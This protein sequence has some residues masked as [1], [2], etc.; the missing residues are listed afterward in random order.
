MSRATQGALGHLGKE[1][2]ERLG[3]VILGKLL[4]FSESQ[5]APSASVLGPEL[6]DMYSGVTHLLRGRKFILSGGP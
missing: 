2:G 6:W 4:S 1:I 5:R 3:C